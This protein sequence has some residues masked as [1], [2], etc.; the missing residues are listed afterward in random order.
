MLAARNR[1]GGR[2]FTVHESGTSVPIELGAEFIH[3]ESACTFGQLRAAGDVAID[4][5]LRRWILRDRHLRP[6]DVVFDALKRQLRQVR[7]PRVDVSLA[8]FLDKHRSSLSPSVRALASMLAEGFDAADPQRIS[9]LEL[10]QEWSGG[11]AADGPTFRPGRGYGALIDSMHASLDPRRVSL[12]LGTIVRHIEWRN[13]RVVVHATRH[14]GAVRIQSRRAIITLPLGV[15][16]LSKQADPAVTF[17]PELG[18]KRNALR[19][20]AV[21]AVI[22]LVL[23]FDHAFWFEIAR[24]R[25]REA[26]FL[27]AADAPFP[28]IWTSLP[29]RAP[30]LVA[31]A[32]GPKAV[33]LM[34]L[35]QDQ[36]LGRALQTLRMLFGHSVPL[37]RHLQ[38][39]HWHDWQH[40]A[41]A[42]GA[43]SY[44]LAGAARARASLR[45]PVS[46]T[47]FFAGEATSENESASVGGAIGSGRRAA[48]E[49]LRSEDS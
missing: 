44:A 33:E 24:G 45:R 47:L 13:G 20:L 3:G 15:L 41:Y 39:V 38:S 32:G 22:K 16:Q 11:A 43:Y 5:P 25:Y 36:L 1:I 12:R 17:L 31:W 27:L 9:A 28:T 42:C 19:Q 35:T 26:A 49:V 34:S 40:D 6:A 8:A 14:G 21:G 23:R 4:V 30:L 29:V 2:V 46:N 18:Q 48:I 10:L 7:K 37:E